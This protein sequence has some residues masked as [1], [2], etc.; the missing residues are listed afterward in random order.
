MATD[1]HPTAIIDPTVRMGEGVTVGPYSIIGPGV[2]LGDNVR[3]HPH[4]VIERDSELGAGCEVFPFASIGTAPQDL[5]YTPERITG[6]RIGPRSIIHECATVHRAS[7]GGDGLT[8]L[9]AECF[10][11]AYAHVAHDCKLG[12]NVI[13]ANG[14]TLAGHV[15]IGDHAFISGLVV[16]HQ[17]IRIGPQ[18]MVGGMSRIVKDCPPYS[19]VQG[20]DSVK[21]YGVNK[22]GLE[23]RG[24]SPETMKEIERAYGIIAKKGVL[25]GEAL[26]QV[27]EELPYSD[28]VRTIVEFFSSS[29]K[30]G[31]YR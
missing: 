4:A 27:Q 31:T 30:R 1:I 16:I 14:A 2:V 17:F 10:L 21:F 18:V 19:I 8:E 20:A 5:K 13:M 7:L 12:N 9:G 11:M 15:T 29:G 3:I 25:L 6:V 26:R 24:F 23:R 28:E 22:I